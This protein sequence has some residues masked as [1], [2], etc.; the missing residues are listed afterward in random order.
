MSDTQQESGIT[1]KFGTVSAIDEKNCKVRVRVPDYDNLRTAWLTVGQPK[2]HKDKFYVLPDI[3]EQVAVLLDPR[4]ETGLVI[5]SIFSSADMPPVSSVDKC[6]IRFADGAEIEYDRASHQATLS[7]GVQKVVVEVGV[8]ILLKAGNKVTVDTPE[9]EFTGNLTV[10]KKLTYK[11]GMSGSGGG[12]IKGNLDVD[13]NV[14][15][16]GTIMDS[17]GNSNH[18]DH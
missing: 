1:L 5:C 12:S 16:T 14:E 2:T 4:G 11:G 17:G 8:D 15:A 10:N 6:H 18:H 7:G 13:G 9:A 3:G